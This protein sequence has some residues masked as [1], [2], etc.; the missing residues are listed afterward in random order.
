MVMLFISSAA[1][2]STELSCLVC[3]MYTLHRI[4]ANVHVCV[5]V[6]HACFILFNAEP[7]E[8]NQKREESIFVLS[9]RMKNVAIFSE[10]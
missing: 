4:Y 1:T 9:F 6:G 5:Y 10:T 8:L 3:N 2:Y 7:N